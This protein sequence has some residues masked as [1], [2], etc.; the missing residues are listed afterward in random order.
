MILEINTP[1]LCKHIDIHSTRWAV[2]G[3]QV[4]NVKADTASAEYR[5]LFTNG[6]AAHNRVDITNDH[7]MIDALNLGGARRNSSGDHNVVKT[8]ALKI[9]RTHTCPKP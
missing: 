4:R 3:D 1:L 8:L 5:H 7:R 6:L 9:L 2:M